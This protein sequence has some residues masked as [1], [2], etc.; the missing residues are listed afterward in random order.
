MGNSLA[1]KVL[2]SVAVGVML[3]GHVSPVAAG[4]LLCLGDGSDPDCCGERNDG[5]ESRLAGSTQLHGGSDCVCC[6]TVDAA[7]TT[8]GASP[9][10]ASLDVASASALRRGVTAPA[11]TRTPGAAVA[12]AGETSLSAIRT[13]VL[14]I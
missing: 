5:G 10:K 14:L 6:I 13:V 7:P 12:D 11:E 4:M 3:L 9:H 1:M 8:A 2:A